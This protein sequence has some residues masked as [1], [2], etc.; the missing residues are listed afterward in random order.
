MSSF[1][2]TFL[3][4]LKHMGACNDTLETSRFGEYDHNGLRSSMDLAK[5]SQVTFVASRFESPRHLKVK[6][7][8]EEIDGSVDKGARRSKNQL[9]HLF[10]CLRRKG[11]R[12][13]QFYL[14]SPDGVR[15]SNELKSDGKSSI[16]AFITELNNECQEAR[17]IR[18]RGVECYSR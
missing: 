12:S 3:R 14:D 5:E 4:N 11:N 6:L 16:L 13:L 1:L 9:T 17:R 2:A 15:V 10:G 18:S 7:Y 8:V